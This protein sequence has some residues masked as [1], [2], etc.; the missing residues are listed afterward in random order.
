M[1][2]SKNENGGFAGEAVNN[3]AHLVSYFVTYPWPARRCNSLLLSANPSKSF[4]YS[5]GPKFAGSYFFFQLRRTR[6]RSIQL[7]FLYSQRGGRRFDTGLVH[8]KLFFF[9]T[10][11]SF[12]KRTPRKGRS[13]LGPA[14]LGKSFLSQSHLPQS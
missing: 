11:G 13:Q 5:R 2:T 12:R 3:S 6:L 7:C 14:W 4:G 8:Q 10:K 1:R 9:L